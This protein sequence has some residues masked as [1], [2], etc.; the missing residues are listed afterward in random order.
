MISGFYHEVDEKSIVINV[1]LVYMHLRLTHEW[2]FK[3]FI[4]KGGSENKMLVPG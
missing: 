3:I 1:L 4:K 2:H